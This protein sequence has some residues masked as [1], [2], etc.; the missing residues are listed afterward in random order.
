MNQTEE[1]RTYEIECQCGHVD[2]IEADTNPKF[3]P[4]CGKPLSDWYII[5]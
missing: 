2:I 3:C 5:D 1:T 4:Q